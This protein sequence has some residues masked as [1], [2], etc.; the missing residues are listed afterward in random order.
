MYSSI[1]TTSCARAAGFAR[2]PKLRW[3]RSSPG[4]QPRSGPCLRTL[5]SLR[6]TLLHGMV[7]PWAIPH[8]AVAQMLA[9]SGVVLPKAASDT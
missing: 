9:P 4:L 5:D 8:V 7:S 3:L 6:M 1:A 2:V